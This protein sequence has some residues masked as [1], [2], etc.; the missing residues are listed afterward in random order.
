MSSYISNLLFRP[1]KPL[2]T[3]EELRTARDS[4]AYVTDACHELYENTKIPSVCC[5][6]PEPRMVIAYSHGNSENI[7]TCAWFVVE[8]SRVFAADVFAYEY[9][10]Y[11]A[12]REGALPPPPSEA[13]CFDASAVFVGHLARRERETRG[14]PVVLVGYSL[15]CAVALHAAD[16]HRRDDFP[17][18]LLLM[19]PF[20]SA[21]SVVLAPR[22]WML[23]LTPFYAP[24]DVFCMRTAA[25]RNGHVL[26]VAHGAADEVIPTSHGRAIAQWAAQHA[27]KD[28]AFLEVPD[29]THASLRLHSEV[30][31][32][33]MHFLNPR[34]ARNA[35]RETWKP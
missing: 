22:S 29:A 27:P 34:L 8:L 15:G 24:V 32:A 9:A 19:A 3:Y 33:F 23:S 18:A 12:H 21:A 10:G 35:T 13:G 26:F 1:P 7:Q 17:A 4:P 11:F 14:L 5:E 16:A 30:Y 28:V 20:V 6:H 25:L 31:E 2:P